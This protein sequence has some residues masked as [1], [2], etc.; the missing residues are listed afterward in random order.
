ML[1]FLVKVVKVGGQSPARLVRR[2]VMRR[3]LIEWESSAKGGLTEVISSKG[4]T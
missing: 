1:G 3:K 2:M 4:L